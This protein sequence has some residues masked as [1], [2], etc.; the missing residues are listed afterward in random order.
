MNKFFFTNLKF[1]FT[2]IF[3]IAFTYPSMAIDN[4]LY[5]NSTRGIGTGDYGNFRNLIA[6]TLD[7]Y[8]DGNIFNVDFVKTQIPGNLASL[9]DSKPVDYYNQI[10]FDTTIYKTFVLNQTDL[11]ALNTW[12]TNKQPEFI[13]D[14][15]FFAR[16][17]NINSITNSAQAVTI[18]EALALKNQGGGILIGT[19]HN[20]F[21]YNA[22]LL[23]ANFGF[24]PFFKNIDANSSFISDSLLSAGLASA[25]FFTNNLQQSFTDNFFT[26]S[27][28]ITANGSFVGDSLLSPEPVGADF[29]TNNLQGL[30]T[31][32]VP[33]GKHTL[34]QNGGNRTIE[35]F[36]SLYS[37]SPSK[38]VHIG[39]SFFTGSQ[40]SDIDN[41]NQPKSIAVPEPSPILGLI[42]LGFILGFR[43]LYKRKQQEKISISTRTK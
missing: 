32:N 34:N 6:D 16:A 7:N 31:S 23:L 35:I 42:P 1:L 29:F 30:S 20:D 36:E 9:L 38:I 3:L 21:A 4:I 27:Y 12:A 10:W 39:T 8:Q 37:L 2:S 13:L 5:L 17:K 24:D 26:G 43:S 33:T 19:D 18:N 22:N 41:P 25:D 40:I 14:S 15:S 28:L 11:L